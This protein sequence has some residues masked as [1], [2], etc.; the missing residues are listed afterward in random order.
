MQI[1]KIIT[2]VVATAC[3]STAIPTAHDNHNEKPSV[4]DKPSL[5]DGNAI[6][7]N[8]Q[9]MSCC[10]SG[11]KQTGLD[12]LGGILGGNCSPLDLGILASLVRT[13]DAAHA[14]GDQKAQ[15]C[16]GDQYGLVNIQ[17]TDLDLL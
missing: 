16:T 15:C 13:G 9:V 10:N 1:T 11:D 8:G 3:V 6:C 12:L 7:G 2:T 17:C 14:C 5:G 4:G